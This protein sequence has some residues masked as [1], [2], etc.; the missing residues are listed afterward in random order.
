MNIQHRE[1]IEGMEYAMRICRTRA[2]DCELMGISSAEA[3]TCAVLIR[4]VQVEIGA[5]RLQPTPFTP[6]EI[7]EIER[8]S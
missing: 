6:G 2:Q 5:G 8:I 7:N 4:F 3:E 1:F